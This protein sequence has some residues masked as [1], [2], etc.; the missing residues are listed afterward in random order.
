MKK[1]KVGRPRLDEKQ[2]RIKM[3]WARVGDAD[4]ALI[5]KAMEILWKKINCVEITR[6][7]FIREVVRTFSQQIIDGEK[8]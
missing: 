1:N 7:A 8:K 4:I 2:A 3:I 6:S 5:D